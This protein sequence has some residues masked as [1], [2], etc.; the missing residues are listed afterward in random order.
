MESVNKNKKRLQRVLITFISLV[1]IVAIGSANQL[2][3]ANA[4]WSSTKYI[5]STY[6]VGA[7]GGYGELNSSLGQVTK[8]IGTLTPKKKMKITSGSILYDDIPG[9]GITDFTISHMG[10]IL[11]PGTA[12]NIYISFVHT[13]TQSDPYSDSIINYNWSDTVNMDIENADYKLAST[14]ERIQFSV[15]YQTFY[16]NLPSVSVTTPIQSQCFSEQDTAFAPSISV[17]DTNN[18]TLTCKCY[19]DYDTIAKDTKIVSNTATAQTVTFSPLNMSTLPQGIHMLRFEI[20][21]GYDTVNK[22][23]VIRVDKSAP[24]LNKVDV[25][26]TSTSITIKASATDNISGLD[27]N[28]YRYTIGSYVSAWTSQNTYTQNSLVANTPYLIKVEVKD[29]KGHINSS[30]QKTYRTAQ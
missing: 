12:Y 8:Y 7:F 17:S 21:D 29:A 3:T 6:S 10:E 9:G 1:I 4:A 5:G 26:S 15:C 28:A 24:R 30:Y 11:N 25:T 19:F 2:N 16:N 20:S 13:I 22:S 27:T 18:D 14:R 23:V